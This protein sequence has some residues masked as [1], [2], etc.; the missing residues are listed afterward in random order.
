MIASGADTE[1]SAT[2]ETSAEAVQ[3]VEGAPAPNTGEVDVMSVDAPSPLDFGYNDDLSMEEGQAGNQAPS[4]TDDVSLSED[5]PGDQPSL[6]RVF[7]ANS[8]NLE[9]WAV[10]SSEE[11]EESEVEDTGN[12]ISVVESTARARNPFYPCRNK[13]ELR[14]RALFEGDDRL[15]SR[16]VKSQ[17]LDLVSDVLKMAP[18]DPT[19]E[20]S[21]LNW[22]MKFSKAKQTRIPAVEMS[23][24]QKVIAVRSASSG[25]TVQ[26]MVTLYMHKPSEILNHLVAN[27]RV[28]RRLSALPDFTPNQSIS[29]TQG[30][31]WQYC[32]LFQHPMLTTST[33]RD[34]WVG[35]YVHLGADTSKAF[36]LFSFYSMNGMKM[37][38]A[39]AAEFKRNLRFTQQNNGWF[40]FLHVLSE[41]GY[42]TLN[43][44]DIEL[45]TSNAF[46]QTLEHFAVS[47]E[48]PFRPVPV[49]LD[50]MPAFAIRYRYQSAIDRQRKVKIVPQDS[51]RT[52]P[53]VIPQKMEQVRQLI[54]GSSCSTYE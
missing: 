52:K 48:H 9:Q 37:A 49:R 36:K 8:G 14:L 19:V 38:K 41:N 28:S 3:Q 44:E 47:T 31:K 15:S 20:A 43:V 1:N 26:Q 35:N 24:S 34:F 40:A 5:E 33:G 23:Q 16:Q 27:P 11:E 4:Q 6:V 29:L 21:S 54:D 51:S 42:L 13:L 30:A 18:E 22:A 7:P 46:L 32:E 39:C 25:E 17:I 2:A 53:V 12:E 50:Q 45:H 10:D